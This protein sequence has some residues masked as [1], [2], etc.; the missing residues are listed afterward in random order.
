VPGPN[1]KPSL[2]VVPTG[3]SGKAGHRLRILIA[4][5]DRDTTLMLAAILRDEGDEVHVALRGDEVLEVVRLFRPDALILDLNMPGMSG[6]AIAHEVRQRYGNLAPMMIA[7]SGVWT[8]TPDRLAGQAVGFDQYLL[9]P[10]EPEHLLSLLQPLRM[11][12]AAGGES[13]N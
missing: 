7:M 9:K 3:E 13:G 4:D 8:G 10:C 6:Y 11:G 1:S 2:R 5:D 12:Q